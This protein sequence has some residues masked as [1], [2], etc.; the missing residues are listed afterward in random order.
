M[1]KFG[2]FGDVHAS[3]TAPRARR[4]D[5]FETVINKIEQIAEISRVENWEFVIGL[6]DLFHKK[7]PS[8]NSH[9]LVSRLATAFNK[10]Q[11]KVYCVV[12]N[13]DYL[14]EISAVEKSPL[15]V[16]ARTGAIELLQEESPLLIDNIAIHAIHHRE[17]FEKIVPT[18]EFLKK[19]Y[20]RGKFNIIVCHQYILPDGKNFFGDYSNF[21]DYSSM[22][23][24]M[25]M[26]G[27]YHPGYVN[28]YE[29]KMQNGKIKW[30]VNPGSITRI[31]LDEYGMTAEPRVLSFSYL[32]Y[33]DVKVKSIPLACQ[34][35]NVVLDYEE[36]EKKQIHAEAIK[37]FASKFEEGIRINL[38]EHKSLISLLKELN[39]P[40]E[41]IQFINTYE[42]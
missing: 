34:P 17:E 19:K 28:G 12:G 10:F 27:H 4:D 26:T 40:E 11:C 8:S 36:M 38:D 15:N 21:S 16:L 22:P 32:G 24:E 14:H 18:S 41:V 13:H 37:E 25:I 20:I 7:K 35:A 1:I 33:N 31:A 29:T 2:C 3:D 9:Y 6:G 42:E 23:H 5:Y 39:T 30:F